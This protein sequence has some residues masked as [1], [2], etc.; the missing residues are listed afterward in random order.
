MTSEEAEVLRVVVSQF[1]RRIC[2]EAGDHDEAPCTG[3]CHISNKPVACREALDN[4][5]KILKGYDEA[6]A[7]QDD[8]KL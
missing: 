7:K 6:H 2:D 1:R 5:D 8:T 3:S 4:A